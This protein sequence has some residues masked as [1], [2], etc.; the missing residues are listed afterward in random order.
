M[1][2]AIIAKGGGRDFMARAIIAKGGGRAF[3]AWAIKNRACSDGVM[4][5]AIK[6]GGYSDGRMARTKPRGTP[7]PEFL[8]T[9]THRRSR[10]ATAVAPGG[11]SRQQFG[12]K[13]RHQR[14]PGEF[15]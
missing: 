6:T 7:R 4:A 3:M 11:K 1:A 15:F 8:G 14:H 10:A 9:G 2:R 13:V 5:R 12:P